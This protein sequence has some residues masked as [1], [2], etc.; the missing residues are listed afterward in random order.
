ML[1]LN[2]RHLKKFSKK[3]RYIQ[4]VLFCSSI[5]FDNPQPIR[6][7]SN[8]LTN[9]YTHTLSLE[10]FTPLSVLD[11]GHNRDLTSPTGRH[12]SI[13]VRK[14]SLFASDVEYAPQTGKKLTRTHPSFYVLTPSAVPSL[15]ATLGDD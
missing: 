14:G 6:T 5:I 1:N 3:F 2:E 12:I 4:D 15:L 13:E 9:I 11:N 8:Y 7:N 10:P